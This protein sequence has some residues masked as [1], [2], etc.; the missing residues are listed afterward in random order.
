MGIPNVILFFCYSF[1][2]LS[3]SC[4]PPP[5]RYL[6]PPVLRV[7]NS[8]SMEAAKRATII[9]TALKWLLDHIP[10]TFLPVQV[11]PAATLLKRLVPLLGYI[12]AFIAW[13]WGAIR[14]FDRGYGVIL[15]A[16]WLLPVALIPGAWD[17]SDF[18][19]GEGF[20]PY[21]NQMQQNQMQQM[22][23]QASPPPPPG[24]R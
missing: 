8:K 21:Y 15:S 7:L 18:P 5:R 11:R 13:S 12:G 16:T 17:E 1:P 3:H 14:T 19:K 22:Q 2:S 23:W 10:T 9:T 6:P 4:S 20:M 24:R